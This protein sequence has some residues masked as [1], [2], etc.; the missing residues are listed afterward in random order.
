MWRKTSC[1]RSS[2]AVG[3]GEREARGRERA[4]TLHSS[5]SVERVWAGPADPLPD[6]GTYFELQ[7]SLF[8]EAIRLIPTDG[9]LFSLSGGLDTRAVFAGLVARGTPV[10][11][12]TVSGPR[13]TLDACIAR[14]LCHAYGVP[15]DVV[16]L[17]AGFEKDLWGW[18][19][20][21]SRGSGGLVS[22]M[23]APQTFTY[24]HLGLRLYAGDPRRGVAWQGGGGLRA[25]GCR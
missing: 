21:A 16:S 7:R 13:L 12:F 15:H 18:A 4:L 14:D 23:G 8:L 10:P 19:G 1:A 17:S 6:V 3:S 5:A 2:I 25:S 22:I 9:V 24:D 20:E 11:A